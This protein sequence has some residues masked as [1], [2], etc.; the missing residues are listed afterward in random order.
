M[1]DGSIPVPDDSVEGDVLSD[2]DSCSIGDCVS[3]SADFSSVF[4]TTGS[5]F[6]STGGFRSIIILAGFGSAPA[7]RG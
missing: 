4:A 5:C 3:L 1:F 6:R 2:A 7:G